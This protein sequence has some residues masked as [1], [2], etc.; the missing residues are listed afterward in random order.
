MEFI[1]QDRYRKW[2]RCNVLQFP[3]V[4]ETKCPWCNRLVTFEAY[5]NS[6][7]NPQHFE[8]VLASS[9]CPECLRVVNFFTIEARA[10]DVERRRCKLYI[11]PNATKIA[12]YV[13]V[14]DSARPFLEELELASRYNLL[15]GS[16]LLA[17]MALDEC[18][19]HVLDLPENSYR[20]KGLLKAPESVR[21]PKTAYF[22]VQAL[23]ELDILRREMRAWAL[24]VE[25]KKGLKARPS[26]VGIEFRRC[27]TADRVV[28]ALAVIIVDLVERP[29]QE[30][31]IKRQKKERQEKGQR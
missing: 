6:L 11:Y 12:E 22:R 3:A 28:E 9:K 29:G 19:R 17:R 7:R 26:L 24:L 4:V 18:L 27:P 15:H 30:R 10:S 31:D 14:P 16:R 2:G 20:L 25:E 1:P 8:H 23:L 5:E 13:Y 21:Q